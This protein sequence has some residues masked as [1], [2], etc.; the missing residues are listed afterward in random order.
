MKA[1]EAGN[2][3]AMHNLAVHVRRADR[4]K[5]GLCRGRE[6]V[7]QGG[8]SRR[9]R[10]PVQS[11]RCSTGA[12]LASRR[13]S[14][15]RGC[16]SRSPPSRATPTPPEARRGRSQDGRRV[17]TAAQEALAKFK[18]RSRIPRPTTW[19]RRPAAGTQAGRGGRARSSPHPPR[20]L[21]PAADVRVQNRARFSCRGPLR[22][23]NA[24]AL[25]S[26]GRHRARASTA[27]PSA[28]PARPD[29]SAR[30]SL[31]LRLLSRPAGRYGRPRAG[32][33]ADCRRAARKSRTPPVRQRRHHAGN[34][35]RRLWPP[36]RSPR[37]GAS[38]PVIAAMN[39]LDYAAATVGNH[40]FNYGL[41]LLER[42]SRGRVFRSCAAT[43]A[44]STARPI[45]RP[46]SVLERVFARRSGKAA[47]PRDRRH[48]LRAAADR[49]MGQGHLPA[50]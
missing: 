42:A 50:G 32:G 31:P 28:A 6:L 9:A 10:Q 46:R 43:F 16:G 44:A 27:P 45:S 12:G 23:P 2:A 47:T 41:D 20:G 13:T 19:P 37:S 38:H 25:T 4:R 1:A 34:A 21:S 33:L 17:A 40:E 14:A 11:R 18:P 26:A 24:C 29:G 48:R 39:G 7:P 49:A 30:Q 3:R 15:S 22:R 5:A 35:A 8:R 36:R